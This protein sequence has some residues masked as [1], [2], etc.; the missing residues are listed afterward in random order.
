MGASKAQMKEKIRA[1]DEVLGEL[2][3]ALA[4]DLIARIKSGEASPAELNAAIKFLADNNIE[5]NT[6]EGSPVDNLRALPVFNDEH[7]AEATTH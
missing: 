3:I 4:N 5:V 2:H 1:K 7:D 6:A